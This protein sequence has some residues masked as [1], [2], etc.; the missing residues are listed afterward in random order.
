MRSSDEQYLLALSKV[1]LFTKVPSYQG[2]PLTKGLIYF[3]AVCSL[4]AMANVGIASYIYKMEN[5]WWLSGLAGIVV[6]TVFNFT[7]SK[8][9]VWKK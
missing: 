5:M 6:G 2:A 1:H 8:Y 9:F 4:G 3:I 7:L